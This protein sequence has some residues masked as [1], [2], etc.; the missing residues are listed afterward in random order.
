MLFRKTFTFKI[1]ASRNFFSS[2]WCFLKLH[3]IRKKIAFYGVNWIKFWFFGGNIFFQSLFFKKI[4]LIKVML[5]KKTFVLNIWRVVKFLIH[6]S[7]ALLFFQSKIVRV[8][9]LWN[10]N[11]TRC[12]NFVSK[13]AALEN[14]NSKSD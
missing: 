13:S 8:V 9:K 11:L 6:K 3:V 5:F 7:N 10:Q 14:P 1:I 2:K 12:E 4:S